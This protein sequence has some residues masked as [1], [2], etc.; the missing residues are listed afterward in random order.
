MLPYQH[1]LLGILFAGFL[2]LIYPSIGLIGFV[3]ILASTFLI[4]VDHYLY[5]VYKKRE[6]NFF[7]AR[8]WFIE[9]LKQ[10]QL[11]PREERNNI[12][13][14][15]SFLHGIEILTLLIFLGYFISNYFFFVFLGFGFHLL[16]DIV[17]GLTLFD[18]MIKV[19][20]IK[21]ILRYA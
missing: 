7:K 4:D 5:Y 17:Y 6:F 20:L 14:G 13:T 8:K 9:N 11:L 12:D 10:T 3:L 18:K 2:F 15:I 16:L 1:L 19:S 21:D